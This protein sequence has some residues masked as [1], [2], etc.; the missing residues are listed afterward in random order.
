M[1]LYSSFLGLAFVLGTI[2]MNVRSCPQ[3]ELTWRGCV[4]IDSETNNSFSGQKCDY[5][6]GGAACNSPSECILM[7]ES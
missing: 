7:S 2:A 6:G 1:K 4:G 3:N 5:G